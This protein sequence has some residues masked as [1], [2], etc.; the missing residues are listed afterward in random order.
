MARIL[1]L[2]DK[3]GEVYP[4]TIAD[5]LIVDTDG[6]TLAQ[7]L[8]KGI[9]SDNIA[10]TSINKSTINWQDFESVMWVPVGT[11]ENT[12]SVTNGRFLKVNIPERYRQTSLRFS[13]KWELSV[14]GWLDVRTYNP[15]GALLKH[16]FNRTGCVLG[17]VQNQGANGGNYIATVINTN[18]GY[19]A[20]T[21]EGVSMKI[22][23]SD[24]YRSWISTA[25]NGCGVNTVSCLQENGDPVGSIEIWTGGTA[26]SHGFLAVW[27]MRN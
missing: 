18:N 12:T 13:A 24:N 25:G 2:H 5:A 7:K 16:T 9:T 14:D 17:S 10:D 15:S 26:E 21:A 11:D 27:A 19:K 6:T 20:A 1:T 8:N 22:L 3:D 23:S 4:N